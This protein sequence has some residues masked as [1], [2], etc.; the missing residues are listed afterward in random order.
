MQIF[1]SKKNLDEYIGKKPLPPRILKEISVSIS[2]VQ[3][4]INSGFQDMKACVILCETK[5]D[6][7]EIS[8]KF[9]A[10]ET[11]LENTAVISES[12]SGAAKWLKQTYIL[13]DSGDGIVVFKKAGS[14]P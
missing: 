7:N 3:E 4:L 9:G 6:R 2:Q 8:Q 10:D 13:D 5:A 14:C 11:T 1:K 12:E